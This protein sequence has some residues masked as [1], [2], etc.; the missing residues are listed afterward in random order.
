[1]RWDDLFADL[2]VDAAGLQQRERDAEIAERTRTELAAL[3]LVDRLRAGRGDVVTLEVLGVG[4]I[5]GLLRRVTPQWLLLD[6]DGRSG[7]AVALAALTGVEGLSAAAAPGAEAGE[8]AA[9]T[10]WSSAFRVLSR[11]REVVVVRRR[12]GSSVRGVPARVGRDFVELWLRDDDS[13]A[14]GRTARSTPRLTVVPYAAVAAVALRT[15]PS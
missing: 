10:T 8:V 13:S 11:D 14:Q 7:W 1:M 2:E 6:V 4:R 15:G 12:D 5:E 9:R 3:A